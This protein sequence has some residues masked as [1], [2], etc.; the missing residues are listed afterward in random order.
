MYCLRTLA[1]WH[2][3]SFSS[4]PAT[5]D[6]PPANEKP[7]MAWSWLATSF[8]HIDSICSLTLTESD[9][10][11]VHSAWAARACT[12]TL[13]DGEP[14][15]GWS[16]RAT[17]AG[18]EEVR[19]AGGYATWGLG[20]CCPNHY[21]YYF[22]ITFGK[23]APLPLCKPKWFWSWRYMQGKCETF[24]VGRVTWKCLRPEDMQEAPCI[25][26]WHRA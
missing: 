16:S 4:R 6:P 23:K 10:W 7:V 3:F 19:R 24:V 1:Q 8:G 14:W 18:V 26:I 2:P 9:V 15:G 17:T 5:A 12:G 21:Q 13:R 11:L 25:P 20:Q 22:N